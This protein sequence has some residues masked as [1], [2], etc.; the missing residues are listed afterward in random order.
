M[1]YYEFQESC[2]GK[3][4]FNMISIS[5]AMTSEV[6]HLF[7]INL[8]WKNVLLKAKNYFFLLIIS[9]VMTKLRLREAK[10]CIYKQFFG[11]HK[12]N[13]QWIIFEIKFFQVHES[14]SGEI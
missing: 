10:V 7:P 12:L 5:A 4:S 1:S 9:V 13:F 8:L 2:M 3:I 14:R 6:K 11:R